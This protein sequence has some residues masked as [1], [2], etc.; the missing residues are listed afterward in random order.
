[1]GST[2]RLKPFETVEL[3]LIGPL[4]EDSQGHRYIL[5]MIDSFTRL[6]ELAPLKKKDAKSSD[7]H[8]GEIEW[9]D[10][11]NFIENEVVNIEKGVFFERINPWYS[12]LFKFENTSNDWEKSE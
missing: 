4:P 6:S 2:L 5:S 3:D 9:S 12:A 7:G 11:E 1:M 8:C 10:K